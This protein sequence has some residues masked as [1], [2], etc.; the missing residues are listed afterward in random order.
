MI[1]LH[2]KLGL[3]KEPITRITERG[4][5][6][7]PALIRKAMKLRPGQ[8]VRWQQISER[9]CRLIVEPVEAVPGPK[10]MLGYRK[11]RHKGKGVETTDAWMKELREGE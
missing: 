2:D 5:I 4:Q 7:L 1:K 11:K 9:E 10:A 8:R 6:S 3:V